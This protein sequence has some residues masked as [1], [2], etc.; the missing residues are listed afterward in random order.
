MPALARTD[1]MT[2]CRSWLKWRCSP[3]A[4]RLKAADR[5]AANI[6]A[7]IVGASN[8]QRPYPA[9]AI[10][11][12]CLG[13]RRVCL[14]HECRVLVGDVRIAGRRRHDCERDMHAQFLSAIPRSARGI[15]T[16][17][18]AT[19]TSFSAM[20]PQVLSSSVWRMPRARTAGKS[21]APNSRP[22]SPT[23]SATIS[24]F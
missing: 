7:V 21:V 4:R 12:Q 19:A 11:I 6:D 3:P 13:H 8:M 23:T 20:S 10:E 15:S 17:A 22:S 5:K 2:N 14:R 18:I 1:T 24:D 9:V 16:S